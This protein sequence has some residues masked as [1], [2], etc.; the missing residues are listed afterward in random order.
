ME[1]HWW[2]GEMVTAHSTARSVV[3]EVTITKT[4]PFTQVVFLGGFRCVVH[5]LVA[6]KN[7]STAFRS[8]L[9]YLSLVF[10]YIYILYILCV[11]FD[12]CVFKAFI[13]VFFFLYGIIQIQIFI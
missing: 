7:S 4:S 3:C 2:V 10:V 12:F 11:L 8:L 13:V 1:C 6:L 9:M 5:C